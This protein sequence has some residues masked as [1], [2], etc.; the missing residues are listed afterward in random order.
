MDDL[1]EEIK[2]AGFDVIRKQGGE[3]VFCNKSRRFGCF[4]QINITVD[5]DRAH[6]W[7]YYNNLDYGRLST[8]R[9][10]PRVNCK[11]QFFGLICLEILKCL[12]EEKVRI[13]ESPKFDYDKWGIKD[14]FDAIGSLK[15]MQKSLENG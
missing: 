6:T 13:E 11:Q 7:V 1:L 15:N 8:T 10:I 2:I 5:S 12:R 4:W 3:M 9:I 14:A